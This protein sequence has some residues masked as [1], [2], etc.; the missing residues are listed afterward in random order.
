M[1]WYM[2]ARRMLVESTK[3]NPIKI[4]ARVKSSF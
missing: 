3:E 1:T 2:K 4:H